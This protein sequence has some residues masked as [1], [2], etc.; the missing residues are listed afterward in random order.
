MSNLFKVN[1]KD[2]QSD[3]I[4][5][6]LVSLLL[7]LN[8]ITHCSGVFNVDFEQVNIGWVI[9]TLFFSNFTTSIF[10]P[11]GQNDKQ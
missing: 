4:D 11:T 10:F 7:T 1:N 8:K 3:I 6:A 2:N 9:S 5:V